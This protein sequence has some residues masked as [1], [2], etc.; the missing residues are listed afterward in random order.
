MIF[1]GSYGALGCVGSMNVRRCV[2]KLCVIFLDEILNI[3]GSFIVQFMQ[4]WSITA[5]SE[6]LVH[7][8]VGLQNFGAVSRLDRIGFDVIWVHCV[9]DHNV[10]VAAVG[11][12]GKTACLVGEEL[13]FDVDHGHED[14][15]G[16]IVVRHL[17]LFD[18]VVWF[19]CR[20]L[21]K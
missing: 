1:P 2:L 11:S 3:F 10:I 9:E 18:H 14:H 19:Q 21:G 8:I 4:L 5:D 20:V 7:F 12:Y 13:A 15:V 6:E 17:L 16:F